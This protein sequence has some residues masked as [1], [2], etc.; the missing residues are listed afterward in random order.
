MRDERYVEMDNMVLCVIS[1]V[2]EEK[3]LRWILLKILT[4]WHGRSQADSSRAYS[5]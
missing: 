5:I 2:F 1:A 4:E 3:A